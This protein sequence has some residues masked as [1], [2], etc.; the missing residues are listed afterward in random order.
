MVVIPNGSDLE[1]FKR[2]SRGR[3]SIREELHIP[4]DA[5]VIGL[6]ARFDPQK[7]HHNFVQAA[8][9][10]HKKRP[11]V[12]FVLCGHHVNWENKDLTR[13]IDEAGIRNRVHLL[14]RRDDIAQL[15]SAFDIA[16]LSS[17][18]EAFPNVIGEAMSCEV[19]CVVTDVGDSAR[20]VADTG[21]VVP[22]RNP[23]ALAEA[24]GRMFDLGREQLA[25]MGLAAR[26]RINDHFNLPQTVDRYHS[27]L[28]EL[29]G[30]SISDSMTTARR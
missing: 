26:Q 24:W 5:P 11:D 2:D 4:E 22:P 19:P 8:K 18:G 27:L 29:A 23:T 14:G 6:V 13:W 21:L 9:L 15:T 30:G 7:D 17:Y 25:Q 28:E 20:I 1:G 16:S 12:R 10:L 3:K